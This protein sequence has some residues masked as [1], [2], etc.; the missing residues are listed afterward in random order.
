MS[1]RKTALVIGGGVSGLSTAYWLRQ[2]GVDVTLFEGQSVPG[3]TIH[4]ILDDEWLIEAGPNSA[5]ETTP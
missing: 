3:G 5:L 1:P 2:A 4:T